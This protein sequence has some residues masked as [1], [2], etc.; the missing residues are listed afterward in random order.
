MKRYGW[1]TIIAFLLIVMAFAAVTPEE[2][3]GWQPRVKRF[4]N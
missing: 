3:V 4:R 1:I 2:A